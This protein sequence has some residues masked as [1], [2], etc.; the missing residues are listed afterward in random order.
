M[1]RIETS[2]LANFGLLLS[3][4]T[5]CENDTSVSG[6]DCMDDYAQLCSVHLSDTNTTRPKPTAALIKL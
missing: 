2:V 4:P 3:A 5:M 6:L 1:K